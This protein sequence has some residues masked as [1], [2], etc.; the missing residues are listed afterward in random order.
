ML[1]C[2]LTQEHGQKAETIF[3]EGF[4]GSA[5]NH[6]LCCR[7]GAPHWVGRVE[8]FSAFLTASSSFL[9]QISLFPGHMRFHC[10][11]RRLNKK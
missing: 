2:G 6:I 4:F 7:R 5:I 8:C 3:G 11:H 9:V 10:H 1:F